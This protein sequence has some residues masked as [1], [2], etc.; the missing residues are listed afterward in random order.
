MALV[1][2]DFVDRHAQVV[3][4]ILA[5]EAEVTARNLRTISHLPRDALEMVLH[6]LEALA[7]ERLFL[8]NALID[9]N[10]PTETASLIENANGGSGNDAMLG[11]DINNVFRGNGGND[12][13]DGK[14]GVNTVVYSGARLQYVSTLLAGGLIQIADQRSGT[15]DGTD[16]VSNVQNF[17]FSDGTFNL[18][19]VLNRP[20][21]LSPDT[22]SPHALTELPGTT[23]SGTLDQVLGTLSFTDANVGDTHTASANLDSAAWSGGIAI[24]VATQ[25]AL[26]IAMAD[27]IGV[28]GTT[29]SLNWQFGLADR[30]VDFLAVGET[31]TAVYDVTVADHHAGSSVSDSAT[32][33]VTVVFTGTNDST[34]VNA[35]QSTLAGSISEQPAVTGSLTPDTTS[36]VIAFSDPDL[37]DRPTATINSAGVTETWQDATHDFT[38]ELTPAQ[39]ASLETA[40]TIGAEAGNTNVGKIDWTYSIVDNQIDFLSVGESLTITMPV[41]IDDHHGGG[42]STDVVLTINGSNDAPI[43]SPDSNGTAKHSPHVLSAQVGRNLPNAR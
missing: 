20:P 25:T 39:I 1:S 31:L 15:P 21:V 22:G 34:T 40:F 7:D 38:S 13:I 24:P 14:G 26:A 5:E 16:T 41:V 10:N 35:A 19:E 12:T 28:D 29:G 8:A 9:P 11:N 30:N 4:R 33:H 2:E 32:Q 3:V 17:Q 42:I 36:G 23:N 18:T 6:G 27:S 43:S 37:N